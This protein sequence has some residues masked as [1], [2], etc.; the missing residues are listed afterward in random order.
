MALIDNLHILCQPSRCSTSNSSC[1]VY[2]PGPPLTALTHTAHHSDSA[3]WAPSGMEGLESYLETCFVVLLLAF[4]LGLLLHGINT[5][6]HSVV[7]RILAGQLSYQSPRVSLVLESLALVFNPPT[8]G[9]KKKG[10]IT[11]LFSAVISN[12][13]PCCTISHSLT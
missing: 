6:N 4:N 5:R 7:V 1:Q 12:Q 8:D 13:L 3:E 9:K 10:F 11:E 2:H